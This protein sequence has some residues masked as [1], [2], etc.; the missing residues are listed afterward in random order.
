MFFHKFRAYREYVAFA[1]RV[2]KKRKASERFHGCPTDK[3]PSLGRADCQER[4]APDPECPTGDLRTKRRSQ[5]L[6]RSVSPAGV[7]SLDDET[8]L[9]FTEGTLREP[10]GTS[11][12][13][14]LSLAG[15]PASVP[16]IHIRIVNLDE[17]AHS[18]RLFSRLNSV[19]SS[20]GFG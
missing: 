2:K 3:G 1:H 15:G 4:A 19:S 12:S 11:C 8:T 20:P 9:E 7:L 5:L 6:T 14:F 18:D 13:L 17:S 16:M 10:P